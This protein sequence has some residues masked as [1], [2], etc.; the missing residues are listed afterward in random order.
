MI[1]IQFFII[2]LLV[3]L[4]SV[5]VSEKAE[6]FEENTG[7]KGIIVGILLA[8]STSLP[9]LISGTT[10]VAIGQPEIAAASMLGSNLFNFL[11]IAFVALVFIKDKPNS[12]VDKKT[13][14]INLFLI[15]IYLIFVFSLLC[16]S[17]FDTN[18]SFILK[19]VSITSVFTI[20][21]YICA[22]KYFNS[23]EDEETNGEL[24][25]KDIIFKQ[26]AIT[27]CLVVVLV[28]LSIQLARYADLIVEKTG[29]SPSS[30]GAVLV[31]AST[32]L[33]EFVSC[34]SLMKNKKYD[35]AFSAT[36]GSNLF[37]FLILGVIDIIYKNNIISIFSF[38][39]KILVVLGLLNAIVYYFCLKIKSEKKR[40]LIIPHI[41]CI[42]IYL[43]YMKVFF[44]G[45]L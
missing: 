30:V 9:E 20:I 40:L 10:S 36:L 28:F 38:D 16:E 43:A 11:I 37:N 19:R 13:N 15:M 4:V 2:A 12:Q 1:F 5:R 14:Q 27:L 25:S 31:G 23:G 7:L 33:P 32:S 3:I 42:I 8:A 34:F 26:L 29:M 41:I 35:M 44:L 22:I 17:Y 24:A 18:I 6:W 21:I 45:T 39:T